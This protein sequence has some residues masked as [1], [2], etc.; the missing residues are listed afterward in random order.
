MKWRRSRKIGKKP[1]R[2][3]F[4][5]SNAPHVVTRHRG[6]EAYAGLHHA[7]DKQQGART[8]A[9]H[10]RA[11]LHFHQ[12]TASLPLLSKGKYPSRQEKLP[13]RL[14]HTTGTQG[15]ELCRPPGRTPTDG[16]KSDHGAYHRIIADASRQSP[17]CADPGFGGVLD[18]GRL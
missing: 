18:G 17:S 12:N 8:T 5:V 15:E 2:M 7:I 3:T 9:Q 11:A 1:R 13:S 6:S 10:N 4:S 14:E 16:G